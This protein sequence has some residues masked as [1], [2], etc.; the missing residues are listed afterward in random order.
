MVSR[1]LQDGFSYI[2]IFVE[3]TL[4][5]FIFTDIYYLQKVN[6]V[7]EE[8]N[9]NRKNTIILKYSIFYQKGC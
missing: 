1:F 3:F 2:C 9:V 7:K 6:F 8:I 4:N 5:I